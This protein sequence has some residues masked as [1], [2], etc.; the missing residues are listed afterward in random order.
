LAETLSGLKGHDW[1]EISAPSLEDFEIMAAE[2]FAGLPAE[3]RALTG[4]VPCVVTDFPDEETVTEME[5]ESEFDIL[6]LFRGVGLPQGAAMDYTGQLPN[7]IWL[8]RRPILDYWAEHEETL[9]AIITHV[10]VH[11]IGHHFG[12]SDE[13]MEA[14][15][16]Q[17]E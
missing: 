7:Q 16:G 1:A 14:I 12:F 2:A 9:G 17:A 3:F 4:E 13:D 11:E 15:E 10:L 8:Y 5:L 6:G